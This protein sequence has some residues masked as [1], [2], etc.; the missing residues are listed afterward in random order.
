MRSRHSRSARVLMVLTSFVTVWCLNCS[1][2]EPL[3]DALLGARSGIMS[4]ASMQAVD[5]SPSTSGI[6]AASGDDAA[7][8]HVSEP[9][10]QRAGF[11]CGCG[12]SC[13]APDA[14]ASPVASIRAFPPTIATIEA[15]QPVSADRMPLLPP[16]ERAVA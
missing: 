13:H 7:I 5:G 12:G 1:A 3:L 9:G 14:S 10:Y 15:I 2:F 11:D 6:A 8:P 16:P 4:C